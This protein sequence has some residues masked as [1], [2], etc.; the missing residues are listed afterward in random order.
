M[1]NNDWKSA[2]KEGFA[3]GYAAAKKEMN[4]Q[5]FPPV[6][7][8]TGAAVSMGTIPGRDPKASVSS[9]QAVPM[10]GTYS[11]NKPAPNHFVTGMSLADDC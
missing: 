2:Y 10:P 1:M 9:T 3:D 5:N 4:Y 8:G 6:Y 7:W 11:I